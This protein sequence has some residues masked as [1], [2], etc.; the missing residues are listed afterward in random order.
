MKTAFKDDKNLFYFSFGR[1]RNTKL[2]NKGKVLRTFTFSLK[3]WEIAQ[4]TPTMQEFFALD[5][6]CCLDCPMSGNQIAK[7]NGLIKKNRK[8]LKCYT[9]KHYQFM[10]FLTILRNIK[11]D[12]VP[13]YSEEVEQKIVNMAFG[14][15]IRF[16]DYGEPSLIPFG[17]LEKM[18]I[19]AK[20]HT[21]YTHQSHKQFAQPF[22]KYL[23]ASS[24]GQKV[25]GWK[26]FI[27]V[28]TKEQYDAI[29]A[30]P[31]PASK[32]MGYKSTCEKCGI[33]N[34][35]DGKGKKVDVKIFEHS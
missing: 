24:H 33:C 19:F 1:S 11:I 31:C 18:V 10:G 12:D 7:G 17:L 6:S 13:Y 4:G 8:P 15:F 16:G 23:R 3:Q 25:E 30:I 14:N 21:G 28:T 22:S 20:N 9:H 26:S 27:V 35:T 2:T 34:G 29:D 32:E 5:E